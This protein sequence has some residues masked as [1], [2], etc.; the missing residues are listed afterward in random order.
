MANGHS[1]AF[2]DEATH[3]RLLALRALLCVFR[4][5]LFRLGVKR[6]RS[7]SRGVVVIPRGYKKGRLIYLHVPVLVV[8]WCWLLPWRKRHKQAPQQW[9]VLRFWG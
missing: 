7:P 2:P 5:R 6:C 3:G 9:G 8:H 1:N 4:I